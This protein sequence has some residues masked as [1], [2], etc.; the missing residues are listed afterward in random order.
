MI[1][2]RVAKL[3]SL[4]AFR[5]LSYAVRSSK[6]VMS[7][8]GHSKKILRMVFGRWAN[9]KTAYG[10]GLESRRRTLIHQACH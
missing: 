2:R 1:Q 5:E 6:T 8:L 10:G 4:H 9:Q 7:A 3:F